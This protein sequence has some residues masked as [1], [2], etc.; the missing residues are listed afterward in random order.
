MSTKMIRLLL[1]A[2][3]LMSGFIVGCSTSGKMDQIITSCETVRASANLASLPD[4]NLIP[5]YVPAPKHPRKTEALGRKGHAV[6]KYKILPDGSTRDIELLLERPGG[7]GFGI[8]AVNAARGIKYKP[9][10]VDGK[11]IQVPCAL[12][13][14]NF[15]G[16]P[17]L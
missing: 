8:S 14:Y 16:R 17:R 7:N 3:L 12:Y 1:L 10:I 4:D 13:Q 6:V 2:K 9:I 5:I 11:P 15:Y